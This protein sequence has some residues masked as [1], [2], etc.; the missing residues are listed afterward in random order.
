MTV[1]HICSTTSINSQSFTPTTYQI[2]FPVTTAQ[3]IFSFMMNTDTKGQVFNE[4]MICEIKTYSTGYSWLTVLAP[5]D[6]L[7]QQFQL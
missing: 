3:T 7:T 1:L 2:S 6:P 5:A 4:A